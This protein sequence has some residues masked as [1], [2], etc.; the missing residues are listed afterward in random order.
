MEKA[1]FYIYTVAKNSMGQ[2][3]KVIFQMVNHVVFLLF[4]LYLYRHVY[5]ILPHVGAKLPFSNAIWSMSIYFVMFWLA[6]NRIERTFRDDIKSGNIEMYLLR[7]LD[8]IWQKVFIQIGLGLFPFL[9]ALVLSVTIDYFL[10]GLPNMDMPILLWI[11]ATIII[12]ITSQTLMCLMF[13]LCGLSGFWIDNSEPV[14][15]IVSKFIMVLGGAWVPVAFFPKA[16]Q[17]FA[18]YSPFGA[19]MAVTYTMYPNFGEHFFV[20]LLN[21]LFWTALCGGAV[22]TVSKRALKKLAVNG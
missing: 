2:K 4:S 14:F 9:F 8:Y 20:L 15:F 12:F 22:L 18:E 6:L 17:L 1:L 19:A 11:L 16:L 3:K 10:V 21:I 13:V 7:P 5:E